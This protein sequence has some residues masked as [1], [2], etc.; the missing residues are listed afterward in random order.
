MILCIYICYV[1]FSLALKVLLGIAL[2]WPP[3]ASVPD[4]T[5][6]LS[7]FHWVWFWLGMAPTYEVFHFD[8]L[9][10]KWLDCWHFPSKQEVADF[11]WWG[12]PPSWGKQWC[13]ADQPFIRVLAWQ[14]CHVGGSHQSVQVGLGGATISSLAFRGIC[15]SFFFIL[16]LHFT[17]VLRIFFQFFQKCVCCVFFSHFAFFFLAPSDT[18]PV[19]VPYEK[20]LTL[21]DIQVFNLIASA[22]CLPRFLVSQTPQR[23]F[24]ICKNYSL[25]DTECFIMEKNC[26]GWLFVSIPSRKVGCM[27][28]I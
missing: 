24:Q 26:R 21:I 9:W 16:H 28:A 12:C 4:H 14:L 19:I 25:D 8:P 27:V 17:H 23:M 18:L 20:F 22:P 7:T 13:S 15:V 10:T 1:C 6:A 2:S 5:I 3:R 11:F